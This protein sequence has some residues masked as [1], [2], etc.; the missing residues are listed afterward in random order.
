[1]RGIWTLFGLEQRQ[2]RRA[3]W[4]WLLLLAMTLAF[5]LADDTLL[6]LLI[7]KT[8]SKSLPN[9]FALEAGLRFVATAIYFVW[10]RRI[11]YSRLMWWV[12]LAYGLAIGG[13]GGF[14]A[15]GGEGYVVTFYAVERVL[16]TLVVLHWG[17][18]VIDYF[19]VRE[20]S[21]VLPFVYS[22]QPLGTVLAG[23]MLALYTGSNLEVL[24][25]PA[26]VA[27]LASVILVSRC[28]G[29]LSESK[30]IK[31]RPNEQAVDSLWKAA[32]VYVWNAPVVRTMA[33]ATAGLVVARAV[34]QVGY[35]TALESHYTTAEEIGRFVGVYKVWASVALFVVQ[36]L[37]AA[38][39][40][41]AFSPTRVNFAYA[42][43]VGLAFLGLVFMPGIGSV[44][45]AK[46]MHKESKSILKTPF[47]ILMYGSMEDHARAPARM[48]VFGVVI[49]LA[50]LFVGL[51]MMGIAHYSSLALW[52]PLLS[53]AVSLLFVVVTLAQ[54]RA[55][56]LALIDALMVKVSSA[57][58]DLGRSS[59]TGEMD[60]RLL[61]IR[62]LRDLPLSWMR[63]RG[64]VRRAFGTLLLRLR[65]GA[66]PS[67]GR[68]DVKAL[69]DDL[70]LVV[71]LYRPT[72]APRLR[73]I[74]VRAL[75]DG[76]I[77]LADHA[78]EIIT[79][80]LPP[81]WSRQA[82][83]LVRVGLQEGVEI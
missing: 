35:S 3:V 1:M 10:I 57:G 21:I 67:E 81:R 12:S 16:Q 61:D 5:E 36:A 53:L 32:W 74:L 46:F 51:V 43:G 52:L 33:L 77:D 34:L 78:M 44:L 28:A 22:A 60:G 65:R 38:R 6:A 56:K 39:L 55:Y 17:V 59:L 42:S 68:R 19:T 83:S 79:S 66:D 58:E 29:L 41:K 4:L 40:M 27:G 24:L 62:R 15:L 48:A 54:N 18:Y 69:L 30:R 45:F 11:S 75:K 63:R 2:W 71:E 14:S 13:F 23:A 20:S 80:I 7:A 37:W 31:I 47:S 49:P 50:S 9:A 76:R 64:Y 82:E 25:I 73:H 8:G 72:A 26:G 70:L